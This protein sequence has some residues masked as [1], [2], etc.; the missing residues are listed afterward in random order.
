MK[1]A[2]AACLEK[3]GTTVALLVQQHCKEETWAGVAT[4]AKQTNQ[5]ILPTNHSTKPN[6]PKPN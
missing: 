6:Q 3:A 4:T 5:Q 1:R 2:H